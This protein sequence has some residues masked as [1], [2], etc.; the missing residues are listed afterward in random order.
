MNVLIIDDSDDKINYLMKEIQ[1]W[2]RASQI[3]IAKSF[4]SGIK[5][6]K[7]LKPDLVLLDMTLPTSEFPDGR[8]SGRKRFLGGRELLA[9][10]DF[11]ELQSKVI[12]FTQFDSFPGP[13]GSIS[14][15]SLLKELERDYP[16]HLIGGIY[17]SHIDNSW[18]AQLRSALSKITV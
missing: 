5:K 14:L 18:R 2:S 17:F 11:E 15:Q 4:Q 1:D 8:A 13:R 16:N 12:I 7:A 6:L 10:M 9:E 3:S